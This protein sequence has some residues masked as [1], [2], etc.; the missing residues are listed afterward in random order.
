MLDIPPLKRY[1]VI[2]RGSNENA[3]VLHFFWDWEMALDGIETIQ[4]MPADLKGGSD[5][6]CNVFSCHSSWEK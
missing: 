6:A 5:E 3:T 4:E 2:S 1:T